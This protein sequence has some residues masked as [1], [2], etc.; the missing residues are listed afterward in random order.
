M[1]VDQKTFRRVVASAFRLLM[2]EIIYGRNAVY[3]TL[4]ANR[5]Q[6]FRLEVAEGVQEKA[7]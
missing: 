4:R 1:G 5:R 7:A 6:V 3:E 2:K